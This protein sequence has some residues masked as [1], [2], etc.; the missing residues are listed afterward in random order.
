MNAKHAPCVY[1]EGGQM[2]SMVMQ[3]LSGSLVTNPLLPVRRLV[4]SAAYSSSYQSHALADW[5]RHGHSQVIIQSRTMILRE[6]DMERSTDA[7]TIQ[8]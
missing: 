6:G 4:G 5:V 7:P 3:L 1:N 8:T 2:D